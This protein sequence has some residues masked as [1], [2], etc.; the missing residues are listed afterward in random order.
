MALRLMEIILPAAELSQI[1]QLLEE[2]GVLGTWSVTL[3]EEKSI[4]RAL[5]TAEQTETVSDLISRRYAH[6][7][8]FRLLLFAVE[9]PL[10]LPEEKPAEEEPAAAAAPDEAKEKSAERISR[11]ELYQDVEDGTRLTVSFCVTVALSTLVATFGLLRDDVAILIGAMVIAPLLGPNVALSLASALGDGVLARRSAK[12][13]AVGVTIAG[14]LSLLIGILVFVDPTVDS[15]AS[16]TSVHPSDVVL[17]L[18]AGS[19]GALAFTS[20]VATAVIGVMVAV[21][22]LPPIVAAGLLLGSGSTGA[23]FGALLLLVTNLTCINLAGVTTFL[24]QK[25]R[26]RTWWEAEQAKKATRV[27]IVSWLAVLLILLAIIYISA[28]DPGL[29]PR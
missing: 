11:E 9:A 8:E 13:L 14:L 17:A 22:L 24:I 3:G 29:W 20:G 1:S 23:A 15:I 27:A 16:R 5:L 10:P 6:R 28:S 25:I 26:P 18:A 2:N 12:T 19:A 4:T 7:E 21:A